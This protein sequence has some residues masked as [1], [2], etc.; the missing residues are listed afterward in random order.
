MQQ[1]KSILTRVL[2][3]VA[4][5][6]LV[7]TFAFGTASDPK[8]IKCPTGD[9]YKCYTTDNLTVYKGEGTTVIIL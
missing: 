7:S 9:K 4:G 1:R 6:L 8:E 3:A 5:A 2:A